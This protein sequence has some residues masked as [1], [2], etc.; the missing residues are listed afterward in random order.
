MNV[1]V[2]DWVSFALF[3][4]LAA[5]SVIGAVTGNLSRK[6]FYSVQCVIDSLGLLGNIFSFVRHGGTPPWTTYLFTTMWIY[7]LRRDYKRW[8][9]SDDDDRPRKRRRAWL[10][11]KLPKPVVK[12]MEQ[13]T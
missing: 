1:E 8:R 12:P 11:S 9:D 4:A 2:A 13:P 3:W 10:K 5:W 7:F 6:E